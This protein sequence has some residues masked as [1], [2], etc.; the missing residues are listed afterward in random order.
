MESDHVKF[1]KQ[2]HLISYGKVLLTYISL[3]LK[4]PLSLLIRMRI[5]LTTQATSQVLI[6]MTDYELCI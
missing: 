6:M 2:N 5:Y 3:L 1:I 4:T